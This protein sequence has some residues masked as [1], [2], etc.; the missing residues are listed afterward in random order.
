MKPKPKRIIFFGDSI[1]QAAVK[2]NGYI[3]VLKKRVDTTKFE[4][5]GAGIGGNKCMIL[6]K[7]RRRCTSEKARFSFH[8]R[9]H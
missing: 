4:L 7:V 5:L 3:N 6:F 9:R 1:T 8:L 2:G